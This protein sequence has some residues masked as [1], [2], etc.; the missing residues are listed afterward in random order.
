MLDKTHGARVSAPVKWYDPAK[1]HG[2]LE[3]VDCSPDI[4]F[5]APALEAV[6]LDVLLAGAMVACKTA[7][8]LRGREVS[9]IHAV[10]FS[11]A[12]PGTSSPARA[13]V[14]GSTA[15]GPG[16]AQPGAAASGRRIK[17]SVKWFI[18]AKGYGFLQAEDGSG[19][20]FC[21]VSAVEASGHETLSQG[22]AVTCEIV[23]GDRGSQVSRILSVEA[24]A[25]GA[26]VDGPA[27]PRHAPR[28]RGRHGDAPPAVDMELP[29]T[30]KFYDPARGFGFVVPDGGGSEV[31]VHASVLLRSGMAD[32]QP[33]QRVSVRTEQRPR[34]LQA[35]D[36][37]PI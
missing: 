28:D 15:A 5:R 32:P 29:G 36:I 14:N 12:S 17:A 2:F 33:G 9:R 23:Q 21:H 6:G 25:F 35:T 24:P 4:F 1:G 30:V 10:D 8:G 16:P 18:P 7:Q 27:R 26:V 31:F 34:S 11:T 20:M 37:E 3:P 19:D 13:P 22:A